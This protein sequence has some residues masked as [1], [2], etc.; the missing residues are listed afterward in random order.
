MPVALLQLGTAA[1]VFKARLTRFADG[2]IWNG[3]AYVDPTGVTNA[4]LATY[5]LSVTEVKSSDT[6]TIGYQVTI[7]ANAA[8]DPARVSFYTTSYAAGDDEEYG[9]D[10]QPTMEVEWV[11]GGRLDAL[12]DAV[13][14]GST[15]FD[16][17][18]LTNLLTVILAMLAGEASY[19]ADTRTWTIYKRDGST[20]AATIVLATT[21]GDRSSSTILGE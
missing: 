18:T 2:F 3:S 4:Q 11:N 16:G 10:Y 5:V 20:P 8:A 6:T 7:P 21:P 15:T 14:T 13:I 17:V 19:D 9:V 1:Q 12:L